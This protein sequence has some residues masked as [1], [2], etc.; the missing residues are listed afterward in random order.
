LQRKPSWRATAC[1]WFMIRVRACTIRCRCHNS[2]RRSRFSSIGTQIRSLGSVIRGLDSG[3]FGEAPSDSSAV[4]PRAAPWNFPWGLRMPR[5]HY[6][7]CGEY[8][9]PRI[10]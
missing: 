2:C 1:S 3:R 8:R 7:N 9:A 5:S 10:E 4:L 6:E